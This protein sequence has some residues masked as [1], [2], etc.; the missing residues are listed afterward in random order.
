[1]A[2]LTAAILCLAVAVPVAH[3]VRLYKWVDK[4]GHVS[5]HDYPPTNN[6]GGRVESKDFK[7]GGVSA[8]SSGSSGKA[9]VEFPVVLYTAPQCTSCDLARAYLDK[10]K[11]P[12]TDLDVAKDTKLQKELLEKTGTLTVPTIMIGSKVMKG[13]MES[14]LSGELDAA[15]YPKMGSASES[16]PPG[17]AEPTESSGSSESPGSSEEQQGK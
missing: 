11:V 1:M 3:G 16:A 15:G 12:F 8:T 4:D 14:L 5:Y 10:R 13:Y 6:E 9:S 17:E 7:V 2:L